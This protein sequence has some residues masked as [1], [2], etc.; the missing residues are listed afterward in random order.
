MD[1]LTKTGRLTPVI[2]DNQQHNTNKQSEQSLTDKKFITNTSISFIIDAD[3]TRQI[4][5]STTNNKDSNNFL[6]YIKKF[7]NSTSKNVKILVASSLILLAPVLGCVIVALYLFASY[8][9]EQ[10]E[11][12][13]VNSTTISY[14]EDYKLFE[15]QPLTSLFDEK[16]NNNVSEKK[17]RSYLI[18]I[19][20]QHIEND[21]KNEARIPILNKLAFELAPKLTNFLNSQP[22]N[23]QAINNVIK[24]VLI[25][26]DDEDL[27][28]INVFF[29]TLK[30]DKQIMATLIDDPIAMAAINLSQEALKN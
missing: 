27:Y 16:S 7:K 28:K 25:Y 24:T 14:E 11:A 26:I 6:D 18:N 29:E 21:D 30:N 12:T 2:T 5:K 20:Q 15:A 19:F 9:V 23:Q 4:A 1:K 17:V 8:K 3:K 22:N 10:H 13:A